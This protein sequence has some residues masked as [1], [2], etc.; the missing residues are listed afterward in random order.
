MS[1]DIAKLK[2]QMGVF[3]RLTKED[4]TSL[5]LSKD[6]GISGINLSKFLQRED[7]EQ[8]LFPSVVVSVDNTEKRLLPLFSLALALKF[9]KINRIDQIKVITNHD[10][11]S[12]RY[13][14]QSL[15]DSDQLKYVQVLTVL[16]FFDSSD[17][18]LAK[19]STLQS[20]YKTWLDSGRSLIIP[21][22]KGF[23]YTLDNS[24]Y[25]P[26]FRE[27]LRNNEVRK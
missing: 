6:F 21:Y 7:L 1:V 19:V 14:E 18:V 22:E 26:W 16:D 24:F 8:I 17:E 15:N 20:F 27:A 11:V 12:Y 2:K 4:G 25:K 10:I 23:Q 5:S 9:H 13:N 3:M